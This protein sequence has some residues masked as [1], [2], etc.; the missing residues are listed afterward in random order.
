MGLAAVT[1]GEYRRLN[2]QDS[3]GESVSGY[4]AGK[5][6]VKFYEQRV[7]GSSLLRRWKI[8]DHGEQKGVAVSQRLPVAQ[9]IR[10]A[11]NIPREEFQFL[12]QTARK[13]GKVALIGPDRMCQRFD[14]KIPKR[15]IP[16]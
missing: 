10:L 6:S 2:F 8:P 5:P 1:D 9:K 13:P 14:W 11:R 7:E 4:D 3:F 16:A 12:R 15:Y